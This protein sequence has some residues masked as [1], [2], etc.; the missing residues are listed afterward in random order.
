MGAG[1]RYSRTVWTIA[2]LV[3]AMA[4]GVF[5]RTAYP[6]ITWW[7]SSSYSLAA[8][9]LG[10]NSPPGSLL[11]TLIG[12]PVAHLSLGLSPA[13]ALNL[14]AGFLAALAAML[15]YVVAVA[16]LRVAGFESRVG[17]AV[18]AGAAAGALTLAFSGTLWRYAIQF[19]PYV[20]TAV[21]TGLILWTMVR[22]WID[23]DR[24]DA[25]GWLALLG[26]LFGLDFSVHRT[27]A[28]LVPGAL[29]WILLRQPHTLRSPRPVVA[30]TSGLAT[31]LVVHL[32]VI[33]IAAL[34]R[35]TLNFNEPSSLSEFWDYV[36]IKQLG[37]SFLLNVYPRKSPIWSSQMMD[38]LRVLGANFLHIARGSEMLGVLPAIAAAWGIV[39]LWR[40]NRRL[41]A[42][43]LSLVVLQAVFTVLYFNIP[44]DFF[45]DFDR[46]YLPICVTIGVLVA[47]GLGSAMGYASRRLGRLGLAGVG[48]VVVAILPAAQL[49]SHWAAN[50]ASRRYFAR[51]YA[52]NALLGLPRDAIYFT[53]GDNDTFPVMYL[54]SVEGVRPDVTIINLSVANIPRW[55]EQLTKRDPSFPLSLSRDQRSALVKRPWTD[56]IAV[57]PV[58]GTAQQLGLAPA[59]TLPNSISLTVRPAYSAYMLP[60]EIV[61]LDIVRT[62]AWRRPLAFAITGGEG[63]MEWLKPYGRIEGF[64]SRVVP[65]PNQPADPRVLRTHL[66]D[67]AQYRGFADAS[68]PIDDV[69]RRMGLLS[70]ALLSTLL[71]A[72][73]ANAALDA[74]RADRSALLAHLPFD[75]L[76]APPEFR[77]PIEAA[78]GESPKY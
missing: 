64:H 35:S 55:P 77:R 13:H 6:T 31:G 52:A 11:L 73:A 72:D 76:T 45:R 47:C 65:V 75:R 7:D 18:A 25:W 34:T 40:G 1:E 10:I 67:M 14:L 44:A 5:W 54:Q 51:D 17:G 19:T 22:W 71:S 63:A 4:A 62:N 39:A 33:P 68:I 69:S 24:P 58:V 60:A 42:A 59:T 61:L 28:L 48:A 32:L 41:A 20:L 37:G 2:A 30:G 27:N 56:S 74:C 3:A 38:V 12:W 53:V 57:L 46:H 29:L 23:A 50:D 9:T 43:F 66:F 21:F 70:Y 36:T 8:A 26:L 78:C 15:V 49:W 16:M